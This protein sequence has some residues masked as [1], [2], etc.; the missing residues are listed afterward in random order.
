[1]AANIWCGVEGLKVG[2]RWKERFSTFCA[3]FRPGDSSSGA[4]GL[5]AEKCC[6]SLFFYPPIPMPY[7]PVE[8][9]KFLSPV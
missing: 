7:P 5:L 6:R 8:F 3:F 4:L 9:Q 2:E 1:M